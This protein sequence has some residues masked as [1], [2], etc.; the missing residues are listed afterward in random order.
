MFGLFHSTAYADTEEKKE[1]RRKGI[2]FIQEHGAYEFLKTSIPTLYSP[3]SQETKKELIAEHLAEGHNFSEPALVSY[4]EAMIAR[5]DRSHILK[6]SI[7]PVLFILGRHDVAVPIDDG[8]EQ[9]HMPQLSYIHILEN[10]GHMGMV[11]EPETINQALLSYIE[12]C[13]TALRK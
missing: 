9:C 1:T 5:T 10:S 12:L 2:R 7:N 8:L 3:G 13:K 6:E 11:E 4:Y